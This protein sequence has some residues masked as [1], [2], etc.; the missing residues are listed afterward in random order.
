MTLARFRVLSAVLLASSLL[1]QPMA[2]LAESA[3]RIVVPSG[4]GGNLDFSARLLARHLS[5]GLKEPVIVENRPGG[6]AIIGARAV[7]RAPADGRSLLLA[8]S[9]MASAAVIPAADF[10]PQ[11]DFKPVAL[12]VRSDNI[13]AVHPSTGIRTV[14]DLV[15]EAQS[16]PQGL[17]CGVLAGQMTF[18]CQM[19]AQR[20]GNRVTLIPFQALAPAIN[21]L[22]AGHVDLMTAPR[23]SVL[24]LGKGRVTPVASLGVVRRPPFEQLPLLKDT[25]PEV[26]IQ[27]YQGI[28]VAGGTAPETVARLNQEINRVLALPD[29]HATLVDLG[30]AVANDPPEALAQVLAEEIG[31]FKRFSGAVAAAS[32]K[33]AQ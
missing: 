25:W 29:V 12:L 27:S 17:N 33:I 21:A 24:Q 4:P 26:R 20:L 32:N 31:I 2:C 8:S 3:M 15:R 5:E 7:L 16:R 9:N 10:D 28:W 19:L 23:A 18:G 14:A 1:L 11:R 22:V 30:F 6:D 13:L